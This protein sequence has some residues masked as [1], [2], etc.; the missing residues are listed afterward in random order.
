MYLF[1]KI[2]NLQQGNGD[3]SVILLEQIELL[4]SRIKEDTRAMLVCREM[5]CDCVEF[6]NLDAQYYLRLLSSPSL[7]TGHSFAEPVER[8]SHPWRRYFARYLDYSVISAFFSFL[9]IVILRIR[10]FDSVAI[11][12]LNYAVY[13]AAVPILAIMLHYW[14]TTP[15]KWVMGIRMESIHGG[16]LSGGEALYREGKIIWHGMGLFIP[17][18]EIWRKYRSYRQE[19][20]GITQPWNE[21]TEIIYEEW[22]VLKKCIAVLIFIIS[23]VVSLYAGFDTY[24]PTYRGEDITIEEFAE[25]YRDYEKLLYHENEYI[26]DNSGKWENNE[27]Y[28]V[29]I[30]YEIK[31]PDF[32]YNLDGNRNI[33]S[34]TY[35]KNF[36]SEYPRYILP[37]Y[38]KVAICTAIGS[39]AGS[40]NKDI[41]EIDELLEDY[42]YSKLPQNGGISKDSFQIADVTVNWETNIENCKFITEGSLFAVDDSVLSYDLKFEI[43]FSS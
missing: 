43:L 2:K 35:V 37:E 27:Y 16:K 22:S 24:M 3:F 7:H 39:S 28:L 21:D 42:W 30:P 9:I 40:S 4:E 29:D 18:L 23:F 5:Q 1:L 12:V 26:M 32:V 41:I 14:G 8:E 19:K 13:F 20:D 11:T 36:K 6:A 33:K 17:I 31:R 38:C 25:N 15:G 34:I 10:P